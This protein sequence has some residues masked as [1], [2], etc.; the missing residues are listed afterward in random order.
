MNGK[1]LNHI[2]FMEALSTDLTSPWMEQKIKGSNFEEDCAKE[3]SELLANNNA[4]T[5]Q[6]DQEE[7]AVKKKDIVRTVYPKSSV[8]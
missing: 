2:N 3:F 8:D 1:P 5:D 6:T 7:Q 4:N